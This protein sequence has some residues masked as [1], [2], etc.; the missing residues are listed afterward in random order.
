MFYK[1]IN[2]STIEKAPNPLKIEN[3]DVFT[4]SEAI[5]NEQG[6]YR[7]I[8]TDYPQDDKVYQPTYSLENNVIVQAW[9]EVAENEFIE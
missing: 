9:V 8:T 7:L 2:E 6:Y 4:N 1:Y 5:H 3:Q